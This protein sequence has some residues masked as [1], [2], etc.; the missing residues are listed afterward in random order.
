MYNVFFTRPYSNKPQIAE[1]STYTR[2]LERLDE[3]L[4]NGS[5]KCQMVS[6]GT[7][8]TLEREEQFLYED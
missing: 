4:S 7:Y 8:E 1:C 2:A 6:Q 3:E 5:V